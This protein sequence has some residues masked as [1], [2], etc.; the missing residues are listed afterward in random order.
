MLMTFLA[1]MVSCNKDEDSV[2]GFRIKSWKAY[3]KGTLISE[4]IM[5]YSGNRI[6]RVNVFNAI[7]GVDS[8]WKNIEYPDEY[9]ATV[10][11]YNLREHVA[12][13]S[14]KEALVYSDGKVTQSI[15]SQKVAD[16]WI[17]MERID[18]N[19]REDGR[20]ADEYL[21]SY[22]SGAWMPSRCYAYF[23]TGEHIEWIALYVSNNG[24]DWRNGPGN[25]GHT[26]VKSL[27]AASFMQFS[28]V[29]FIRR[30]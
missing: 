3:D 10:T 2:T 21:S 14:L 22:I 11:V 6:S 13:D 17:L 16:E 15:V 28:E 29:I 30:L 25:T 23:Y 18:I 9:S 8:V 27:F 20:V 12:Y 19:Y 7:D 1:I 4:S 26:K 5:K 24:T